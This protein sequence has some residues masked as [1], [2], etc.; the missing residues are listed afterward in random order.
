M[1]FFWWTV[2]LIKDYVQVTYLSHAV[3]GTETLN[4]PFIS[5]GLEQVFEHRWLSSLSH[6]LH[7]GAGWVVLGFDIALVEKGERS[8]SIYY[9]FDNLWLLHL[10]TLA[11]KNRN[12][13]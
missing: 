13:E 10:V 2:P 1:I 6:H 5:P 3:G 4:L 8:K 9:D 12:N 11:K 7:S